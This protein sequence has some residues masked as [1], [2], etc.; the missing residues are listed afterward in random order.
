MAADNELKMKTSNLHLRNIP[1]EMG[2]TIKE[3]NRIKITNSDFEIG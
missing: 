2:P 1:L 3:I